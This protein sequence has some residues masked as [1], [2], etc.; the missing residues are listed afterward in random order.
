MTL[1]FRSGLAS[2]VG[3]TVAVFVCA[4]VFASAQTRQRP[5]R[6]PGP[7]RTRVLK[8]W[9]DTI[10]QDDVEIARHVTIVFDYTEGVAYEYAYDASG[11]LI[12]S[13]RFTTNLPRPSQEEF[14]EAIAIVRADAQLGRIMSRTKARPEGGF[15]LEEGSGQPCGPRTRCVQILWMAENS[16]GLLRRVVVDLTKRSIAYASY[17]PKDGKGGKQ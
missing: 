9:D 2:L 1:H 15:L 11:Q 10:K 3:L 7:A 8:S 12:S 5:D 17:V 6:D 14:E 13:R 16:M 4:P